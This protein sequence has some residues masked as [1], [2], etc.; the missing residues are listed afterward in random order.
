MQVSATV[1]GKN[2]GVTGEEMNRILVKQGFLTGQPC[3]Y[4]V[5]EKA[6]EYAIEKDFHKGTGG[7]S[8][9][10]RYWTT[11][12]FDD[13]IKK[14]LDVTPKLIEDVRKELSEERAIRYAV[15]AA[16]RAKANADFLANETA[17]KAAV[18]AV[19][20]AAQ[21]K[22]TFIIKCK[23]FGLIGAII[24]GIFVGGYSIYKVTPKIKSW[25]K[26]HKKD[27]KKTTKKEEKSC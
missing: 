26:S 18:D 14:A 15:Q 21:S 17:K 9:Y 7:Y 23:K 3:N 2:Y 1:L 27:K 22:K 6:L 4:S 16:E 25:W 24:A 5:T 10:N 13:S 11:R 12:T 19:E 20:K 8:Q